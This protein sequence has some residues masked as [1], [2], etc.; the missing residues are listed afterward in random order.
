M[1]KHIRPNLFI[2]KIDD[3]NWGL[4][5]A[6]RTSLTA[7]G[8]GESEIVMEYEMVDV[9]AAYQLQSVTDVLYERSAAVS[10]DFPQG[11][12]VVPPKP[13]FKTMLA[14]ALA[15]HRMGV[16]AH[17]DNNCVCVFTENGAIKTES[18]QQ[19]F[20]LLNDVMVH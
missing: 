6:C 20:E 16:F 18:I 17:N 14:K 8:P 4:H 13:I 2:R 5:N 9:I 12:V 10:R 1:Q 3:E 7:L 15:L 11:K 19:R